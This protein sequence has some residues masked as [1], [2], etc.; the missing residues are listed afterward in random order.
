[1]QHRL[2][3]L[4]TTS[5][6]L[7]EEFLSAQVDHQGQHFNYLP[8]KMFSINWIGSTGGRGMFPW[9]NFHWIS[10]GKRF[11]LQVTRRVNTNKQYK[12]ILKNLIFS[13]LSLTTVFFSAF[14][15]KREYL[16]GGNL[17]FAISLLL[18]EGHRLCVNMSSA[19]IYARANH[20]RIPGH[21]VGIKWVSPDESG[22][23][24]SSWCRCVKGAW[25]VMI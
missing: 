4:I 8:L 14:F 25:W 16:S 20:S 3:V 11:Y 19:N 17:S 10:G 12:N 15:T 7:S 22:R 9:R 24:V 1:M 18:K 6:F 21:L 13:L 2:K 23:W 5:F